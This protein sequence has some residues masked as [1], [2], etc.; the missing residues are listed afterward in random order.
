V[1]LAIARAIMTISVRCFGDPRRDWAHAMQA[2]FDVAVEMGEPLSFASGCLLSA[3]RELPV[4]EEGR[5]ALASYILAL[6]VIVPV[7]VLLLASVTQ[8]FPFLA[9]IEAGASSILGNG[10]PGDINAANQTG[11]PLLA[12]LTLV[13][14]IGHLYMAWA[15][16]DRDWSRVATVGFAAMALMAT[17]VLFASVLFLYDACALPQAVVTMLELLTIWSL[18]RW[19]RD[20]TD[21]GLD[22]V[23]PHPS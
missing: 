4:H 14:G 8:G 23:R 1:K 12:L 20:L 2:E 16:L 6:G 11:L 17:T 21:T 18:V 9:P 19:D 5:F 3:I 15:M 7:G 22:S 13:L 10:R